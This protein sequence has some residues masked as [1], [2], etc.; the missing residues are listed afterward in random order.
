MKKI[1]SVVLATILT[2][3]SITPAF[4][5]TYE[6]DE[7]IENAQTLSDRC[8]D[9]YKKSNNNY[10]VENGFLFDLDT[11]TIVQF[12]KNIYLET[13]IDKM[14]DGTTK[15]F[16]SLRDFE[17]INTVTIPETIT[18][19][20]VRFI[21]NHSFEDADINQVIIPS[22]VE[23]IGDYAFWGNTL[24]NVVLN[25]GLL[26]IGRY[27]F[28]LCG[29][30]PLSIVIPSSVK[31]IDTQQ[32]K[33]GITFILK[34]PD[35]KVNELGSADEYHDIIK[36][37]DYT[38]DPSAPLPTEKK[39]TL[40]ENS[41]V[42]LDP[43]CKHT[44]KNGFTYGYLIFGMCSCTLCGNFFGSV[45]DAGECPFC[46]NQIS[47]ADGTLIVAKTALTEFDSSVM[48][49]DFSEQHR[50]FEE[51][52][53]GMDLREY[54]IDRLKTAGLITDEYTALATDEEINTFI[55][56]QIPEN[57]SSF[58]WK[59]GALEANSLMRYV[60]SY[61]SSLD[62]T[63]EEITLSVNDIGISNT[64]VF[65]NL[66]KVQTVNLGIEAMIAF[67]G[68]H[69]D[70][71][72]LPHFPF[73]PSGRLSFE[74][75]QV[76]GFYSV[77]MFFQLCGSIKLFKGCE[78]INTI[79]ILGDIDYSG[80][81]EAEIAL[82]KGKISDYINVI[83]KR[84]IAADFENL[85]LPDGFEYVDGAI[86]TN[87]KT[88]LVAVVNDM[89]TYEMPSTVT[90]V[91]N[92]AFSDRT[93]KN[94]IWSENCTYVPVACFAKSNIQN[95]D[96]KNVTEIRDLAFYGVNI[97][98]LNLPETLTK[99][100]TMAFAKSQLESIDLPK[101]L[102]QSGYSLFSGCLNLNSVT[103]RSN[104][105]LIIEE[106]SMVFGISKENPL[107]G[108]DPSFKLFDENSLFANFKDSFFGF[109]PNLSNLHFGAD[110]TEITYEHV[111][112]FTYSMLNTKG[113]GYMPSLTNITVDENNPKFSVYKDFL[114]KDTKIVLA[115]HGKNLYNGN[116]VP[117]WLFVSNNGNVND[118][119]NLNYYK[120]INSVVA[121]TRDY[122]VIGMDINHLYMD[123]NE[124]LP[125]EENLSAYLSAPN[126]FH[127]N[128]D[129]SHFLARSEVPDTL[130]I[131]NEARKIRVNTEDNAN[132]EVTLHNVTGKIYK[133][134]CWTE[135][136]KEDVYINGTFC[137]YFGEE[138][139]ISISPDLIGDRSFTLFHS[140]EDYTNYV[141]ADNTVKALRINGDMDLQAND[142]LK[143]LSGNM[144]YSDA[145]DLELTPNSAKSL[146][147][148]NAQ[149]QAQIDKYTWNDGFLHFKDGFK[150]P[151]LQC[152]NPTDEILLD[153]VYNFLLPWNAAV[154]G[155]TFEFTFSDDEMKEILKLEIGEKLTVVDK[156]GFEN[157]NVNYDNFYF[158]YWVM[159]NYNWAKEYSSEFLA[160]SNITTFSEFK[161]WYVNT[162]VFFDEETKTLEAMFGVRNSSYA[163]HV[164]D[165]S[166]LY[167]S[168][169]NGVPV[170]HI[171]LSVITN[172][173][174]GGYFSSATLYI[175]STVKDIGY[176][177][178]NSSKIQEEI[179]AYMMLG[180]ENG[181]YL[182]RE[183]VREKSEK[184]KFPTASL[185]YTS[186]STLINCFG[187][188]AEASDTYISSNN[189]SFK[190]TYSGDSIQIL[191][192]DDK[193]CYSASSSTNSMIFLNGMASVYAP[194]SFL[195]H[196]NYS[197]SFSPICDAIGSPAE[198]QSVS[199]ILDATY[200]GLGCANCYLV[201][202]D[203][204]RVCPLCGST[205]LTEINES[206]TEK[207]AYGATWC[208]KD[209]QEM[210]C[211]TVTY[212]SESSP[213]AEHCKKEH[214]HT[215]VNYACYYE[216]VENIEAW[217]LEKQESYNEAL[218]SY[219]E[220]LL[221]QSAVKAPDTYS[222]TTDTGELSC[223]NGQVFEKQIFMLTA[224][225][226]Y[227]DI[228]YVFVEPFQMSKEV[229]LELKKGT[230]NLSVYDLD[231]E[232]Y[233]AGKADFDVYNANDN[234]L[235]TTINMADGSAS[236]VIP[237]GEY[238]IVPHDIKG[239][240]FEVKRLPL[241]ITE[242]GQIVN[243]SFNISVQ[244]S[245]SL[246]VPEYLQATKA[247]EAT[248]NGEV[249]L[250][251][252]VL[253]KTKSLNV[254]V[255]YSGEL[256]NSYEGSNTLSYILYTDETAITNNSSILNVP[257]GTSHASIPIR[258]EITEEVL[259]AGV[260]TDTATFTVDVV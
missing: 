32:T 95:I 19:K 65:D 42:Q 157:K 239:Y 28:N 48:L 186:D 113:I 258:A 188:Y 117:L 85:T 20:T 78:N 115:P 110:S 177:S 142:F 100:G 6:R 94:L 253:P 242:D 200:E 58:I 204:E 9:F 39:Y 44:E 90:T 17:K 120:P 47:E 123:D 156:D 214:K 183:E 210:K 187:M 228:G 72:S 127:S 70:C 233:Y 144:S 27:A 30:E 202:K 26:E 2:V 257:Y 255:A 193:T 246:H 54:V 148:D 184:V 196:S 248:V 232:E 137:E 244:P 138:E 168:H 152:E 129:F 241:S 153:F 25:E 10:V 73:D 215:N 146:F 66:D 237:C 221:S 62:E 74:Q 61:D 190:K 247:G 105:R 77:M 45:T 13:L 99:L 178:P 24:T 23:K 67:A 109:V 53:N 50:L 126:Y 80:M 159:K 155:A 111:N 133:I 18:G 38:V 103:L 234:T 60:V 222:L 7:S 31:Y 8:D 260:Y 197:P 104:I 69:R 161:D 130:T 141:Y 223:S 29:D 209:D 162:L 21:G 212:L 229:N 151:I 169:I 147:K 83:L 11:Q 213:F 163:G 164:S 207:N 227:R 135:L 134:P 84:M 203:G 181:I 68:N 230:V 176:I 252:V 98:T 195:S 52:H 33:G 250:T 158:E 166:M 46:K 240:S 101:S 124:N 128:I 167:P 173:Y 75:E 175:P 174:F 5:V 34:N 245:Y 145:Y 172:P 206:M 71:F 165:P 139:Y 93:I 12:D 179:M 88:Q 249:S 220:H 198:F 59:N 106:H 226:K 82:E 122:Y 40:P 131:V 231:N 116:E 107:T 63:P 43:W 256:R 35:T 96:L 86:Y 259:F 218:A 192:Q 160:Q 199:Y 119:E 14:L 236:S 211:A 81:T 201:L 251:D 180:A 238:Y 194:A 15:E 118:V 149:M 89:E 219:K 224:P 56:E 140:N 143:T 154:M 254:K 92:F 36:K 16:V 76:L 185:S 64:N 102:A 22:S 171:S 216:S 189:K 243:L 55:E 3:T 182:S 108:T 49:P 205:E 235:L 225:D 91:N 87:N 114:L 57:A 150:Y 217:T 37:E 121:S 136:T 132:A 125:A 191:S 1:L 97:K 112:G 4:A 79:N 51:K 41:L 170:E 208:Q